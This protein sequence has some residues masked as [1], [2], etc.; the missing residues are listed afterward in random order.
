MSITESKLYVKCFPNS[1]RTDS[2][3]IR[4]K[5]Q[6]IHTKRSCSP[7]CLRMEVPVQGVGKEAYL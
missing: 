3:L 1:S 4:T 6:V 7:E 5:T 2:Q